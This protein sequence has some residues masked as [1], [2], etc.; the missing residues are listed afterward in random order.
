LRRFGIG[1]L[2]DIQVG[3]ESIDVG[4]PGV[5][6]EGWNADGN[7]SDDES[8]KVTLMMVVGMVKGYEY[9]LA[10]MGC[11]LIFCCS[12]CWILPGDVVWVFVDPDAKGLLS[13]SS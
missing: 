9:L 10:V 3:C 1:L 8:M 5:C 2:R 11:A 7:S 6:E 13:L 4:S 12:G